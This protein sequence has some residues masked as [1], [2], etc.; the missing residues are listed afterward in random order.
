VVSGGNDAV[1]N[2]WLPQLPCAGARFEMLA[3]YHQVLLGNE[4][5]AVAGTA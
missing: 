3:D 1:T 4:D 5:V 2:H